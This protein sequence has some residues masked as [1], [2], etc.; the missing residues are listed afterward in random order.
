MKTSQYILSAL[1]LAAA[2]HASAQSKDGEKFAIKASAEIGL[3][4]SISTTSMLP[5]SRKASAGDYGIDFGWTF[6][7]KDRHR[8]EA[9]IGVA[10]R[11]TSL[12]F[13]WDAMDYDYAAPASADM[14]G[15]TYQRY[16]E[17]GYMSQKVD[18]GQIAVPVYLTYAYQCN[19][20]LGFHADLGVRLGFKSSCKFKD[21]SGSAYSY[22]VYP[23]YD[24]LKID[25]AYL[26]N[27]GTTNLANARRI[28]PE[29]SG[30]S[31]SVLVGV[32]A[33]C[34]IYGPL[35]ADVSFRYNAGVTNMF[36]E[37]YKNATS[38]SHATAPVNYT[39]DKGQ[40]VKPATGYLHSSKQNQF[41][42]RMGLI[43]R[44]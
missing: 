38:F 23:Q 10:Y 16:Y 22:G 42:I 41:S 7:E 21:V 37:Q 6:F 15:E 4:N 35:A 31:A 24:D 20:W 1:M 28:A 12:T 27:F 43:Y 11:S 32:G 30:F 19:E 44:F 36:K 34:R 33:E 3:G 2:V 25:D 39:V 40:A 18:L 26:N 5:S 14:D 13:D 17:I 9:N 8:L 29:A